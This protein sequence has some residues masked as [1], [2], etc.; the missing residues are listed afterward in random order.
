M[1]IQ[2]TKLLTTSLIISATILFLFGGIINLHAAEKTYIAGIEAAF[3]PWAYAE[4]GEYK[5]I[6]VDAMREIAQMS[7]IKVEFKDLPWPSLIPAL[8]K[9]EN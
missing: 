4:K 8:G 7:G 2:W 5:G 3:P 6:A 9:G 1:K